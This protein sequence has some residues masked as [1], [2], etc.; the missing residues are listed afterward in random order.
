LFITPLSFFFPVE[1]GESPT[2]NILIAY[3]GS[4]AADAGLVDLAR[5]GMP[6]TGVAR[7]L[8]IADAVLP[9]SVPSR[10]VGAEPIPP[11]LM[12]EAPQAVEALQEAIATAREGAELLKK[13]LPGWEVTPVAQ[14]DAPA[15]GIIKE[16]DAWQPDIVVVGSEGKSA[17]GRFLL[18][19][20]AYK[21]LTEGRCNVRIA[22]TRKTTRQGPIRIVVGVDGSPGA[23]AA[24]DLVAKR[25]WPAGTE[26]L[27]LL[28]GSSSESE[29]AAAL[30]VAK[31]RLSS[32]RGL[33]LRAE[34]RD[35]DPKR[36]LIEAAGDWEADGIY[37]GAR[38]LGPV[39][40]FLLGS[41][42]LYVA[43]NADCSVGVVHIPPA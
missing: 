33:S 11:D 19:S 23:L 1:R 4:R 29:S 20:I 24:V 14:A 16:A 10:L 41:V 2:M 12:K 7:V 26:V 39:D 6:P 18:G 30:E 25:H 5:A 31:V 38:G 27:L 36:E 22:R 8:S 3:D 9:L 15:W 21:V 40:R 13:T 28:C 43:L 37:V 17:L 32:Y 34:T 35:G 42:S